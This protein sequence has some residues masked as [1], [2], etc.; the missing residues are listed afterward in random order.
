MHPR[1]AVLAEKQNPSSAITSRFSLHHAAA[2]AL[3]YGNADFETFET[4]DVAAPDLAALR[5]RI[6]IHRDDALPQTAARVA[7]DC[8]AAGVMKEH[9][10]QATGGPENPL[11]DA[12]LG[13]KFNQLCRRTMGD[14][15]ADAVYARCLALQ[16]EPDIAR[17]MDAVSPPVLR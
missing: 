9:V 1:T 15:A 16:D 6:A 17:F 7:V 12:Q 11:S 2:L 5:Q 10:T 14:A 3:T 4:A 8:G 13:R